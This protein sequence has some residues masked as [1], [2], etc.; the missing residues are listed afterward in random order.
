MPTLDIDMFDN[1][2]HVGN[3][4]KVIGKIESINED[5][6]EVEV[7]YDKVTIVRKRK[8]DRKR[9]DND[10]DD[11]DDDDVFITETNTETQPQPMD[12]DS[13]LARNFNYTR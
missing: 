2:P 7:T 9:S 3:K 6:G 4:V 10:N 13:A 8:S 5:T 1:E 12:L 11:D